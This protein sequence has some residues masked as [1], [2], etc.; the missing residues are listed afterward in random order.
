MNSDRNFY[1]SIARLALATG[2]L[3][4]IPLVAMQLTDEVA[5]NKTDFIV[6]GTLLFG[7]GL[8]YRLITRKTN[9]IIYRFAVGF[10]LLVGLLLVWVNLAVG[11][12]GSEDN[13]INLMYFGVIA[14]GIIGAFIARFQSEGMMYTMFAMT[15]AQSLLGVI[16]LVG[17]FYQ[18]LPSTVFHI[19][20]VNGFFI[21]LFVISALLFRYAEQEQATTQKAGSTEP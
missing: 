19:I 1:Q 13:P 7:T 11:I 15:L 20:G 9:K 21:T 3:L 16:A 6:A 2:F 8:T 12:I 5:W 18:S 17:G 14:V 10:A 4:L